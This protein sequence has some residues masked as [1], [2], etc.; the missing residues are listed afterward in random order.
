[1][2]FFFFPS[3]EAKLFPH[4]LFA[5][6]G[7]SVS[8]HEDR[9]TRLGS[10]GPLRP[11]GSHSGT[12]QLLVRSGL[13][14]NTCLW[15]LVFSKQLTISKKKREGGSYRVCKCVKMVFI[16]LKFEKC[17]HKGVQNK[18]KMSKLYS[19]FYMVVG[20]T[21]GTMLHLPFEKLVTNSSTCKMKVEFMRN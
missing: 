21:D 7:S 9:D 3:S 1:M 12:W 14:V 2:G 16:H 11:I 4:S 17:G 15:V 13:K 18:E 20:F 8:S 6:S 19:S 5:T 10:R